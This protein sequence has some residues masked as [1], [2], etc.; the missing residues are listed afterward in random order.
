AAAYAVIGKPTQAINLLRKASRTGL[1]NYPLFRDDPHFQSLRNHPQ[2]V[3]LL[4]DLKRQW[5]GYK[6]EFGRV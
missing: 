6:R 3:R 1:P 4:A 5:E 2:F